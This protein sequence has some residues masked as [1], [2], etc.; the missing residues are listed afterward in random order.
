MVRQKG[1]ASSRRDGARDA[2][3]DSSPGRAGDAPPRASRDEL[4]YLGDMIGEMSAMAARLGSTTLAGILELARRE[5]ELEL[6][7]R[8]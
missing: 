3:A 6:A 4:A 5:A 8:D 7:R 1:A 2:P